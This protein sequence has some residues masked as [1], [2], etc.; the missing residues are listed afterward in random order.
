MANN[1]GSDDRTNAARN[2]VQ[3]DKQSG[4][5]R[6]RH[7]QQSGA[8]GESGQGAGSNSTSSVGSSGNYG[9][10]G[11]QGQRDT[12]GKQQDQDARSEKGQGYDQRK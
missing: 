4:V 2:T 5:N 3:P 6:D 9:S 11:Q 10:T 8:V 1:K 12:G 7:S